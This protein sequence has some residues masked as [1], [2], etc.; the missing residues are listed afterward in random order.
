MTTSAN[1]EQKLRKALAGSTGATTFFSRAAADLALLGQGRHTQGASV[2]GSARVPQ[3]P[4]ASGPWNDP[5][6][7]PDEPPL[8]YEINAQESVGEPHE[9]AASLTP[10]SDA[11]EVA[12]A[13]HIPSLG[14]AAPTTSGSM[15]PREVVGANPFLRRARRL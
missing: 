1:E 13:S 8:G 10:L 11:V 15:S 3:Y 9:I 14:A 12:T 4:P 6:Q 5:V 7:V 2:T